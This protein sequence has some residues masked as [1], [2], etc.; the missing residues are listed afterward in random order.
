MGIQYCQWCD[1]HIDTQESPDHFDEG[2]NYVE[3]IGYQ[4][5]QQ[6]S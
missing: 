3:F 2:D 6:E 1:R 5:T 4:L